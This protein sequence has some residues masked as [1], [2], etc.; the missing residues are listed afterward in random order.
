MI[1]NDLVLGSTVTDRI[2]GFS[3]IATGIC[4]YVSGCVQVSI[5]PRCGDDGKLPESQWFDVQ[6][7]ERVGNEFVTLDN[8]RTPGFDRLPPTR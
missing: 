2:T 3:G 5:A 8:V 1:E 6:R 4:R 7:L